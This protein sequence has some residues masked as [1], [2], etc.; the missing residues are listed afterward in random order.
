MENFIKQKNARDEALASVLLTRRV[1]GRVLD[2]A[3][4]GS[5]W[6]FRVID[7]LNSKTH[8]VEHKTDWMSA[9]TLNVY[10]E[11]ENTLQNQPSGL[12]ITKAKFWSHRLP[13]EGIVL[14]FRVKKMIEHL[15]KALKDNLEGYWLSKKD[16]GDKNS[17]GILVTKEKILALKWIVHVPWK[18]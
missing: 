5:D 15:E 14:L 6:D 16:C 9:D 1:P 4:K 18:F 2:P 7:L 8:T 3:Q 10:F 17:Q 12:Y 11:T 13:K